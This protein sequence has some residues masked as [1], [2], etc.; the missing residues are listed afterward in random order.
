[1]LKTPLQPLPWSYR[2]TTPRAPADVATLTLTVQASL[3]SR[4][5]RGCEQVDALLGAAELS[6]VDVAAPDVAASVAGARL[7]FRLL[8]TIPRLTISLR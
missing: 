1:M 2:L 7:T 5:C 6:H 4:L 3:P 8:P